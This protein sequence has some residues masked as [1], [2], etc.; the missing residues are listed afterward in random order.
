MQAKCFNPVVPENGWFSKRPK[1]VV[2]LAQSHQYIKCAQKERCCKI[3]AEAFD[4]PE[5]FFFEKW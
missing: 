3:V 5:E 4:N 2:S 1:G